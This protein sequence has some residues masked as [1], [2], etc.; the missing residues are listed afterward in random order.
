MCW[1]FSTNAK[2]EY[3]QDKSLGFMSING[4]SLTSAE[5]MYSFTG[6]E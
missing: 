4:K 3:M 6:V 5:G 1:D 2:V